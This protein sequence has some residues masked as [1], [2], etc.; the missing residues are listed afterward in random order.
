[1]SQTTEL[2]DHSLHVN[3]IIDS[4]ATTTNTAR[5][6]NVTLDQHTA[7]VLC[8][9]GYFLTGTAAHAWSR[10]GRKHGNIIY[11]LFLFH[12]YNYCSVTNR[13][14]HSFPSFMASTAILNY[15]KFRILTLISEFKFHNHLLF[16]VRHRSMWRHTI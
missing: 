15:F 13:D 3:F 16:I 6:C 9:L 5:R 12:F 11:I 10:R 14:R 7:N 2:M 4:A 8:L 1:M